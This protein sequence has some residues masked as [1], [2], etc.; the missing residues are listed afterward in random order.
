MSTST[1]RSP[2]SIPAPKP[3]K[4][5]DYVCQRLEA[6]CLA[7]RFGHSAE[8]VDT[9]RHLI[10][11]WAA[12]GRAEPSWWS[13]EV[14]DDGTPI[15]FSVA[16]SEEATD[17]RVLFE[18]QAAE[19]TLE[20]YRLAGLAFNERLGVEFGAN[21]ERFRAVQDLFLPPGMSGPF[22]V[23]SSAVFSSAGGPPSFKAYF[24][25]QAHG[26]ENAP[27]LVR[28]GLERL[29][30]QDAWRLLRETVFRRGP[31]LDEIKYFALDLSGDPFA[32]VKVYVRHHE[33]TPEDLE[34]SATGAAPESIS[35]ETID[36][37]RA[38]RGSDEPMRERACFTCSAFAGERTDRPASITVYVP[39]C[40]YAL[41][42]ATV[43]SRVVDYM[44]KKGIDPRLYTSVIDGYANR[45]LDGGVGMQSWIAFR[46]Y[47]G[48]VR[49]TVYLAT[50]AQRVFAPGV[51]PAPTNVPAT[52]ST[53]IRVRT[54]SFPDEA[55]KA[56]ER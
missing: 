55:V 42:D 56:R 37:V 40:A 16:T 31:A 36:F 2:P 45:P 19:P 33:T 29:G 1:R 38:I 10:S 5:D 6:L 46:R 18:P 3:T 24:N 12:K 9:V 26:L 7:A 52:E 25:A 50:E 30:L 48:A 17:V 20:S 13:S 39:A 54:S 22:A 14:S 11:P 32:R 34:V 47:R 41:D 53:A 35:G 4:L 21:L 28:E 15:E 23:W 49:L 43:R 44:T 8:V 27:A 51:V